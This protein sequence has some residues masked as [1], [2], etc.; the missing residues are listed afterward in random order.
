MLH[1]QILPK[2]NH[3]FYTWT[4]ATAAA[5]LAN[6][7]PVAT[8]IGKI[9]WDRDDNTFWILTNVTPFSWVALATAPAA[10]TSTNVPNSVVQRDGSGNFATGVITAALTG[11][12][13]GNADTA[14]K[15]ATARTVTLAGVVAGAATFDGSANATITTTLAAGAIVLGTNTTGNYVA[16]GAVSGNGLT[17]SATG[18]DSAFTIASN[19]TAVNA[20]NTIVFR[21]TNGDFAANV[22]TAT[23]FVGAIRGNINGNSDTATTWATARII[24]VNGSS[25]GSVT[26][27]G[28]ANATLTLFP[29]ANAIALGV[30]TSGS[31][32]A[33]ASTAGLGIS[34]SAMSE[35][36]AF[37]ITS[38]ATSTNTA[39]T[40]VYRDANGD[41]AANI[42]T[43]AGFSG[44]ITGTVTGGAGYADKLT[45]ARAIA[46]SG[47]VTGGASFDGSADITIVTTLAS[48][49]AL[50]THTTG[51]YIASLYSGTGV[52]ITSGIG[53]G[54]TPTIAIGQDV[55]TTAAPTFAGLTIN[56][57]ATITGA[58]MVDLPIT[59]LKTL[60]A[61]AVQTAASTAGG[62]S[63]NLPHGTAPTP[64]TNGDIWTTTGGLYGR[65]NGT[66]ELFT[67][68]STIRA[69]IDTEDYLNKYPQAGLISGENE[70]PVYSDFKFAL[71]AGGSSAFSVIDRDSKQVVYYVSNTPT[72]KLSLFRAYRFTLNDSYIFDNNPIA[73]A[74]LNT[75]E[76]VQYMI[77][78]GTYFAVLSLAISAAPYTYT[79]TVIVN[80]QGSSKSSDWLLVHDVTALRSGHCNFAIVNAD[81]AERVLRLVWDGNTTLEVYDT[82]LTLLRS[83]VLVTAATDIDTATDHSGTYT[84]GAGIGLG[85]N[86]YGLAVPFTWNP[87][88][89]TFH[90]KNSGYY[91]A[92]NAAGSRAGIGYAM[93]ISW[94]I[95]ATWL[96]NGSG[97][98]VNLIPIKES[99]YRYH[100]YPDATWDTTG[101][102]MSQAYGSAGTA[103]S[104][105]TDEYSGDIHMTGHGTWS[106]NSGGDFYI[107]PYVAGTPY[108]T[109]GGSV[110]V[111]NTSSA[112]LPDGS[113]WSKSITPS[114]TLIIGNQI[115]FIGGSTRYGSSLIY[116]NFSTT[117]FGSVAATNDTLKLDST[118]AYVGADATMPTIIHATQGP[119]NFSTTVIAGVP[120]YYWISPGQPIYTATAVG[121]SRTWTAT[122]V[123]APTPPTTIG[124]IN[125]LSNFQNMVWNGS[126]SAP[127]IHAFVGNGLSVY[128]AKF[129]GGSWTLSAAILQPQLDAGAG[130]RGDGQHTSYANITT[131]ML[132]EKGRFIFGIGV[133][134]VGGEA[135]YTATYDTTTET[136]AEVDGTPGPFASKYGSSSGLYT[137]VSPYSGSAFGYNQY[138]GYYAIGTASDSSSIRIVCS[139]D[140]TNVG[141]PLTE[142]QWYTNSATRYEMAVSTESATGLVAYLAA[143][144]IFLGGYYTSTP[145]QSVSLVANSINYIFATKSAANRVDVTITT[146]TIQLPN[147]FSRVCIAAVTTNATSVVSSATYAHQGTGLPVQI[148]NAN[149]I[150]AT[151]GKYPYWKDISSVTA[152]LT[153]FVSKTG[154]TMTG[155]LTIH[156]TLSATTKNFLID[157]PTKPGQQLRYGS[158]EG[159][160]NGV[161]VRGKTTSS[162]IELP[163]Y[164]SKLVN[165]DSITVSL[166][167]IGRKQSLL[168]AG[169]SNNK[170]YIINEEDDGAIDCFYH[171]FAER[172]DVDKL[173]VEV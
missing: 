96:N 111:S 167:A 30:D 129:S 12:V 40:L 16:S 139:N 94:A 49:V 82:T 69:Y 98:L 23:E 123:V 101:G 112:S 97:T 20:A 66:T 41:F 95:P 13:T 68:D 91:A 33:T 35:D 160:E 87:L 53:A 115:S 73:P 65:I 56:G 140:I 156:G 105:T 44:P 31:Y 114:A 88:S 77:N 80:T 34:G 86:A 25:S 5:R 103:T 8:E 104:L 130:N 171:I 124:G 107:L 10:A 48:S 147:S 92:V 42:I 158:L 143:Y 39:D 83:Q 125:N 136:L 100:A 85:Y 150:L 122:S 72:G 84:A 57:G 138:L 4:Y 165:A 70:V 2:D 9:A 99:T 3:P 126:A 76:Y 45:T 75:G 54:A 59:T 106:Y 137:A 159:P 89:E 154:D 173:Q 120:I 93:S 166:T 51:N 117:Q 119:G 61:A 132:T 153:S 11:N 157:H 141:V 169:V 32:V 17:G 81:G 62:A 108:E 71:G 168:V 148:G 162:V 38:N 109:F 50:G 29:A 118:T 149:M 27:D 146:S 163:E 90:Q 102:G 58:L 155:D 43:A 19:A 135:F 134:Y 63:L 79:R 164:W 60:T 47:A 14:T 121:V 46:L 78:A 142:D 18:A 127:V 145:T 1:S 133:P 21:D 151:D 128:V 113:P 52:T 6:T 36:S 144:P 26:I 161:Y 116:A 131:S 24:T 170:V 64:P 172:C 152:S 7:T 67:S 22:V 15:L 110:T 55:A 37:V 28:S 74:F